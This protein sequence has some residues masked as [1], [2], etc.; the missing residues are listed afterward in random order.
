MNAVILTLHSL[1][2][3]G[4]VGVVLLQRSEGGALGM[5]GGGGGG[6]MSGRGAA[7]VLTRTTTVLGA[8]FFLTSFVLAVIADRGISEAEIQ[9]QLLGD[10][11]ISEEQEEGDIDASDILG[12][13]ADDEVNLQQEAP[14]TLPDPAEGVPDTARDAV[15]DAAE[16]SLELPSGAPADA[17]DTAEDEP[18]N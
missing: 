18:Q 14:V 16:G 15:G 4:L 3:L 9:R 12:L 6:M 1:I 5:G 8:G 2:V 10:E 17:S 7:N 13:G 11:A